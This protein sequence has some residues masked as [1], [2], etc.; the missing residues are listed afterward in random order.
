MPRSA[1]EKLR[2]IVEDVH[3]GVIDALDKPSAAATV[4][5]ARAL[6]RRLDGAGVPGFASPDSA[7]RLR[8]VCE[9]L[10]RAHIDD[11]AVLDL[12]E[13]CLSSPSPGAT[14]LNV[15]RYLENAGGIAVFMGTVVGARPILEMVT[16]VFGASQYMADI[17]I[18]NPSTVYWLMETTTWSSPDTVESYTEWL[19]REAAMFRG[20]GAKLDAIRRAHRLA[21]LKIG[22][23]D[24]V[25]GEPVEGVTR[26][27]SDLADA[28]AG[29][30]L[31]LVAEELGEGESHGLAVIAMG[32]LGG[33]ELNYSSDIDLIYACEDTD[34][35]A[36]ALYT[37]CARRFTDA[38]SE[39]TSEGYLY[40]VDLRLR[41]DGRA[42]PL[43]NPETALRIY[44]ENRGRPWEFQAMLKA[45]VIAGNC[46]LGERL[47]GVI[48]SLAFNPSLSYS[49]LD[50]IARMRGQIK[51]HIPERERGLNIKLMEGGIRD[52][53]FI[54]QTVQLVHGQ[55]HPELRTPN[56]LEALGGIRRLELLDEWTV[57]NL[58]AAYRFLRLVEHRLQMMHQ[59]KTHTVPQS[60]GEIEL[61]AKR[62][63]KGP[64][65]EF[66]TESFLDTL[67]RHLNNVRTF[68]ES[69]FRGEEVHPHSVLLMLPEDDE[70]ASAI[71]GQHGL[72]DVKRA[73][74]VL[75]TMAY[76][77]FPRLLDRGARAAF[78]DL[79]PLLLEGIAATG[80][81]DLALG[82]VAK[83]AAAVR[84]E[85]SF[86]KLLRESDSARDF[87]L[88]VAGFSSLLTR[89]LCAQIG[90]LDAL[91]HAS[92]E[93]SFDM[94]F[95]EIP[96]RDLFDMRAAIDGGDK[97]RARLERQRAWFDRARLFD[98]AEN[99]R[100]RFQP[101]RGGARRSW[102]AARHVAAAF[103]DAVGKGQPVA[104]FVLGSYA[105]DEPRMSSDADVI[106]VSDGADIPSVTE[107]VQ[108]VNRWFTDGRILKLDFRLRGEG[109]SAPLVQDLGYY[110]SYLDK[111]LSLWERIALSKCRAW[112]GDAAV[113][114]RF[115]DRLSAVVARPFT[116][117]EVSQLVEMRRR[118]EALAPDRHTV[119]ETKRSAGGR[120]DVEYLTAVGLARFCA[121][122]PDY[123]HMTT[124]E[125]LIRLASRGAIGEDEA[126][127]C[128]DA[129]ELYALV[130]YLM[131]LQELTHPRSAEKSAYLGS[132]L[133]RCFELL[134]IDTPAGV[135]SLLLAT[136]THVRKCYAA[137]MDRFAGG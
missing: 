67:S 76:G 36:I 73:M 133:D 88:G 77:S 101:L 14:L 8:S 70:R 86:Y 20:T 119:W 111:R 3:T 136:K 24:L 113:Q 124:S 32:K 116:G 26:R 118:V 127:A 40:R 105:V 71:I 2:P 16:T 7:A 132:Y 27:L 51:E 95:K 109:A 64:L 72:V 102:L 103:D 41:P 21:L 11:D 1:R 34:D 120:Y 75:H 78:E 98:F 99:H 49:P 89:A 17:I 61:L 96:G 22:V 46:E 115:M 106:V 80:D 97:A 94:Q 68:A 126:E 6:A 66:T 31:D 58:T 52:V 44:Y 108:L 134:E 30:V 104:L 19:S 48:G 15:H 42:G 37:K 130:D 129:L 28:V 107:R 9:I 84:S 25:H 55:R 81:P 85:S 114:S 110:E 59:L 91:L 35:E 39:L 33:R 87:A 60:R 131:E 137:A 125:R 54:A 23:A 123:F 93:V 5:E 83:I 62:S 121:G 38:L 100:R 92:D 112:W 10:F 56:T 4:E 69:F 13:A 63:S 117:G 135:E 53:E 128:A 29:V 82:N 122:D 12:L 18:R 45:R 47:L 90:V 50:D 79:L 65:G 74:R 43:V 57:D